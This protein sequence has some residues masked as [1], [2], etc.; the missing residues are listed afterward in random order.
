MLDPAVMFTLSAADARF[1]GEDNVPATGDESFIRVNLVATTMKIDK[2]TERC[3]R[4]TRLCFDLSK[5]I[6]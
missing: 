4:L 6:S 3:L 2:Q 5:L 1:S